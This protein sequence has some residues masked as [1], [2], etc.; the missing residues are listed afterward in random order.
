MN[1]QQRRAAAKAQRHNRA[2]GMGRAGV[3]RY[4]SRAGRWLTGACYV[5]VPAVQDV[6][7]ETVHGLTGVWKFPPSVPLDRRGPA[8]DYAESAPMRWRIEA[9]AMF[10]DER[11]DEYIESVDAVV[12]QAVLIGELTDTW[13][14]MIE[15]AKSRGNPKHHSHDVVRVWPLIGRQV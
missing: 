7:G 8:A 13:R 9:E 5:G 4:V 11:G 15:Q 2:A 14:D 1:R 3:N 6:D 12:G 10:R